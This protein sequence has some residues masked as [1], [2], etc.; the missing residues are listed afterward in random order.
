MVKEAYYFSHD[1]NARNDE[2]ILMLRAEHGWEGYGIY[3]ALIEM[4][5]EA[6]ESVLHHKKIKGIAVSYS[7]DI[8][9][10]QS[11]I[12]TCISEGLFD[13]DDIHFW[14]NSLLRRKEKY[15]EMKNKRSEAGK[16]GMAK[17][18]G[19]KKDDEMKNANNDNTVITKNNK[20][21]E[22]KGKESKRNKD[23]ESPKQ[24]YDESSVYFQLAN[25][26]YENI[27]ENDENFKKPNLQNWANDMR[28]MMERDKRTTE[29][30]EYLIQWT[31]KHS[32]WKSN[33]LS[34][35]KL[36]EKYTTLTLQVKEERAKP[37][38]SYPQQEPTVTPVPKWMKEPEQTDPP[39][40]EDEAKLEEKRKEAAKLREELKRRK[41]QRL[42]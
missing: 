11:V 27:L 42:G 38:R 21:K 16:K 9:L 8:T 41:Q 32:F 12:N 30:I 22:S 5:F 19:S 39:E 18:W 20:G 40:Q 37:K 28:L 4:M 14:S 10:L 2:K 15:K 1:A 17:R 25:K 31:Q 3:W 24:A 23:K 29:Q 6:S 34:P 33:I 7:I 35:K 13:T 36:R 26:L